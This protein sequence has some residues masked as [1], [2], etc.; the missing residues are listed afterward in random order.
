MPK[1][2]SR[3]ANSTKKKLSWLGARTAPRRH[4]A[5]NCPPMRD[6]PQDILAFAFGSFCSAPPTVVSPRIAKTAPFG[7]ATS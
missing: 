1:A 7:T 4:A 2:K 3:P 6:L 5:A